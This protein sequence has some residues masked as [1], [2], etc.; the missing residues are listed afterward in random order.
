MKIDD[1]QRKRT[2][3]T[4]TTFT[5]QE[6]QRQPLILYSTLLLD[7]EP[8]I[9]F[10]LKKGLEAK[11]PFIVNAFNDPEEALKSLANTRYHIMIID[12]KMPKMDGFEFYQK[13]Q[14]LDGGAGAVVA[15]IS[16]SEAYYN[17]YLGKYPR[18]NGDCFIMKP[19]S[20]SS[21]VKFLLNEL[22]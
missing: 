14:E 1:Y 16:A 2:K 12:L 18:W 17:D 5:E 11:G 10:V 19:I 22:S 8:D 20:I 13:A 7:D 15:F 4:S 6:N 9:T 3:T 21:L